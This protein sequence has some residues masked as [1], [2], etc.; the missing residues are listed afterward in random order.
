MA[1]PAH[2]QRVRS[3]VGR[4]CRPATCCCCDPCEFFYAR[5]NLAACWLTLTRREEV[6]RC[7]SLF[8]RCLSS[9]AAFGFFVGE[10]F[11]LLP[12][13][14]GFTCTAVRVSRGRFVCTQ[15]ELRLSLLAS[16]L[17]GFLLPVMHL[18]PMP[19]SIRCCPFSV[20][21]I[22]IYTAVPSVASS[23]HKQHVYLTRW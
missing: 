6:F 9:S 14:C 4:S 10:G 20:A 19:C 18:F 2:I 5:L 11:P 12:P 21:E 15:C 17:P 7:L 8:K 23:H 1:V 13:P 3:A 16:R 22:Y